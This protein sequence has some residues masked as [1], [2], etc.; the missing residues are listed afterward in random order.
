MIIKIKKEFI[1]K[2][3]LKLMLKIK[4]INYSIVNYIVN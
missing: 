1:L 2:Q 3:L 4:I